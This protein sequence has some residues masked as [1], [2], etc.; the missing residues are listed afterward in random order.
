MRGFGRLCTFF[1]PLSSFSPP[2]L[3][4][5]SLCIHPLLSLLSSSFFLLFSLAQCL[6]IA[7]KE[8]KDK[9]DKLVLM[10][11]RLLA[12]VTNHD[13]IEANP[14][15]LQAAAD[16]YRDLLSSVRRG[17]G[18]VKVEEGRGEDAS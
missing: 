9:C 7:S 11:T 8:D 12:L 13:S 5:P 10:N 4:I 6:V 14:E 3:P 2:Q 17:D 1:F 18:T 16:V 15:K